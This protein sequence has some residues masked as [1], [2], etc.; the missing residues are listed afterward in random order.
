MRLKTIIERPTEG[1][2]F[3]R[4]FGNSKVR[5]RDGSSMIAYHGTADEFDQ[6]HGWSHFGT[7]QAAHDRISDMFT[8]GGIAQKALN[9]IPVY[10]SIQ[11]PL[12]IEDNG[13]QDG[14]DMLDSIVLKSGAF[15]QAEQD[16]FE[17]LMETEGFDHDGVEEMLRQKG[18][19]GLVYENVW[20]DAGSLSYIVFD[21]RQVK[22]IY[23]AGEFS[24]DSAKMSEARPQ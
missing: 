20:E 13:F 22:S 18:Y 21:P 14:Y 24:P 19:D 3:A 2:N 23:N 5:N 6:F 16:H 12:K 8:M 9:I 1:A 11:N 7:L 17:E 15:T 10:L 4:W